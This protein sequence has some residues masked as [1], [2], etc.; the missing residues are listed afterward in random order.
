LLKD[1]T[2]ILGI[3]GGIAAYKSAIVARLL[4]K[5]GADVHVIMTRSATEFIGPLTFQTITGNPVHI[6]QFNLIDKSEIGH[7]SLAD[8]AD[9]F[10]VCPATANI[11]GKVANGI[12]DDLLTTS[13][14]ATK[15]PVLFAPSMNVN[16]WENSILQY[17]IKKL[18]EHNYHI[19]EPGTGELACHWTGQGRLAEPGDIVYAA[20]E[21]LYSKP[22][23]DKKIIVTAGPTWEMVDTVRHI[24][25][26]SSGKMGYA[27]ARAAKLWG[28]KVTLIAGPTAIEPFKFVDR[29]IKIE[30]AKDMQIELEKI[31]PDSDALIMCAA[32]ADFHPSDPKKA[33]IA[34]EDM[35]TRLTL[36]KNDDILKALS[37]NKGPRL[38]VGFAAQTD[39]IEKMAKKKIKNKGIDYIVANDVSRPDVGFDVDDNEV[40]IFGSDGSDKSFPKAPKIEIAF[41]ILDYVFHL[42]E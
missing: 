11:L 18:L 37:K 17:N 27:L 2:I 10:L 41:Q 9:L 22:L 16:M 20:S 8:R 35:N 13:I 31:F 6:D 26:R 1:K 3:T 30:S 36:A 39:D 38:M 40:R 28:A 29:L 23:K 21:V 7:I 14:M 19:V 42:T 33:K 24:S 5:A 32:V 34:K 25:N 15:A 12:A 4:Y